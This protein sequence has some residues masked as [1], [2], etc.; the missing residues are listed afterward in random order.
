M[1]SG[2]EL[3]RLFERRNPSISAAKRVAPVFDEVVASVE[4]LQLGQGVIAEVATAVGRSIEGPIVEAHEAAVGGLV[5]VG[6]DVSVA[7]LGSV[8]KRQQRV[9]GPALRAAAMGESDGRR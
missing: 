9:L 4:T 5:N 3:E 7:E 2:I 6:F 8:A 1:E